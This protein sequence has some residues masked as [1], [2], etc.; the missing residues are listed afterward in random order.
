MGES[1]SG[2][3]VAWWVYGW[4][5]GEWGGRWNENFISNFDVNIKKWLNM[6][7]CLFMNLLSV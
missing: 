1:V 3:V 6:F 2:I 4:G 7:V 5:V